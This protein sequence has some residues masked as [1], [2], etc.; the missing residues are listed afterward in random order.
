MSEVKYF[1]REYNYLQEAGEKFAEKHSAIGGY[2]RLSDRERKD[3]FVERLMEAFAFLSGRIHERLDDDIPEFAGG[4][5]EQLFPNLLRPFPSCAVL[6][7]KPVSG[8]ITQSVVVNRGSQV[9]T[10]AGRYQVKYRVSVNPLERSRTIEKSEPAEFIFRTTQDLNILPLTLRGVHTEEDGDGK[11]SITIKFQPNR[12]VSLLNTNLDRFTFYIGG[13]RTRLRYTLLHYLTSY[14][15]SVAVR[16]LT[17]PQ[18][19][20]RV[21]PDFRFDIPELTRDLDPLEKRE[22][23]PFARQNFTG[24]RLLQEYFSFPDK[25]F[26]VEL[27]GLSAFRPED[28][29]DPFEIK[30]TFNKRLSSEFRPTEK[31]IL[32]N[33]VPI[34]NLFDHPAEPVPV[35]RRMPEYY[36]IPDKDRRK[37]R[38][39]YAITGVTGVNDLNEEQYTYT[40]ITSY[41][42]LDVNNPEYEFKRFYSGV[43]RPVEGDIGETSIRI[44]GPSLEQDAFP[45]ETLSIDAIMSNGALPAL[46]LQVDSIKQGTGFPEGM[47]VTNLTA[48]SHVLPCPTR[49]NYI[50]SLIS[51]L[52]ISYT[53]LADTDT[54]KKLL[55]LYN[56][57]VQANDPT[58]KKIQQGIVNVHEP[59]AIK[60][61]RNRALIR[62]IEFRIDID[63]RQFE[64]DVGDIHLFGLVLNRF[65]SQY[66]TINSFI[67]LKF[68]D[69]ETK[70]EFTW[71]PMKGNINPL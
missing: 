60:F 43:F 30:I 2:L 9:Q 53:T 37:S 31:D 56:W 45:K 23:I 66:I 33:C 7:A 5:L 34:V 51:H 8:A 4:L 65:L 70:E 1:E 6:Q 36:I 49:Q 61:Y 3:P 55:G 67:L 44:F 35:T 16:E 54:L 12:N 25:F 10:P 15:E 64:R 11:T 32:I 22:L 47:Q 52:T 29:G 20:F 57:S 48:P 40:P 26:F 69:I 42:V 27:S 28:K 17:S 50:W 38:E 46:Y 41:D 62:G 19:Q 14:V 63:S 18:A 21:L 59:K 13:T 68:V 58:R 39:V 24:Y 71:H